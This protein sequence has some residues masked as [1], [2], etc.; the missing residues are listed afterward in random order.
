MNSYLGEQVV[1][2]SSF[3]SPRD[4]SEMASNLGEQV[5]I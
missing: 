2:Q 4:Q 1:I 5:V 3:K